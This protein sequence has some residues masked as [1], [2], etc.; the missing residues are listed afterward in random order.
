M[1]DP[2]LNGGRDKHVP[3]E[4]GPDEQVPPTNPSEGHACRARRT[5]MDD[6]TLNGGR[7]RHV[8]PEGGPDEQV[9]P[10]NPSE[11]HAR[12]ARR[13]TMD[14]PTLNGGRDRHVPPEGGPDEQ[15]PPNA[16]MTGTFLRRAREIPSC[17]ATVD[18]RLKAHLMH[19][20]TTR[21]ASAF[22]RTFTKSGDSSARGSLHMLRACIS[23]EALWTG[24]PDC[25]SSP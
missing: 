22:S 13:T 6:P 14:D 21:S 12:R 18:A 11:G 7:D 4:G 2:T 8:P 20:G 17:N 24:A 9:P 3:P 10:T 19:C 16:D 1:D 5:A 23:L 15:V 25:T